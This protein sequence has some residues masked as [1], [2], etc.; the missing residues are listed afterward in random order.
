MGTN[1]AYSVPART[2]AANAVLIGEGR[3]DTSCAPGKAFALHATHKSMAA[4]VL[5]ANRF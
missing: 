1:P 5:A 3:A 2:T 4:C